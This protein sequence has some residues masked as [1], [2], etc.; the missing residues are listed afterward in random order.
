M[1]SDKNNM[2]RGLV[3]LIVMSKNNTIV[4]ALSYFLTVTLANY[5]G[6]EQ[7]GIYSHALITASVASIFINFS[8]D[9]TAAI[10]HSHSRD[11]REV[12][13][14]IFL[15]RTVLAILVFA[16][17][18][19]FYSDD[20]VLL[21]FIYCLVFANFNLAFLY[22]IHRRNERY[23]YI[24]LLE[25]TA[26]IGLAFLLIHLKYL[27]LSY[28]FGLLLSFNVAS[29]LFQL[30]DNKDMFRLDQKMPF[31]IML[32][33]LKE[34]FPLVVIAISAYSFGGFSRLIFEGSHGSEMFGIYSAGLQLV[35]I[36]TIFQGQVSRLWRA[37][38]SD[39]MRTLDSK[40]LYRTIQSYVLHSTLPMLFMCCIF[41]FMPDM[42]IALLFTDRYADLI[43][44][45]PL[46]GMYLVVIN[47]LGLLDMLWISLGRRWIYMLTYLI[48]SAMLLG[49]L[50]VYS[51]RMSMFQFVATTV[52][53]HFL[54]A[55]VLAI[56]WLRIFRSYLIGLR[57]LL[58]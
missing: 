35:S 25:R 49:F 32:N 9:Q 4:A 56:I 20:L 37:P 34:N 16:I 43:T 8:T 44:I 50:W 47:M 13:S 30:I 5:L 42:I 2:F 38:I 15:I 12:F 11:S 1:M 31:S 18:P 45:L 3:P 57:T 33:I 58:S 10:L 7:F 41:M 53:F 17:L 39:S 22:E 51:P 55:V 19:C 54:T 24:Y 27:K 14:S 40:R 36:G 28:L 6:P 29:I 52:T 21:A 46:L 23:S 26:Y 48:F